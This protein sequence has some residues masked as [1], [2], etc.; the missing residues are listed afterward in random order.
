MTSM[1]FSTALLW[2]Q[3][4]PESRFSEQRPSQQEQAVPSSSTSHS[5]KAGL[6]N[7]C[8]SGAQAQASLN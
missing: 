1:L 7:G 2:Y 5:Y 4:G 8:L 3:D 6:T